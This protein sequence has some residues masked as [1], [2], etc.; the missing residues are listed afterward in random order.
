MLWLGYRKRYA[1]LTPLEKLLAVVLIIGSIFGIIATIPTIISL[2]KDPAVW[3]TGVLQATVLFGVLI[4]LLILNIAL[5]AVIAKLILVL[6]IRLKHTSFH[7]SPLKDSK[8]YLGGVLLF[9]TKFT[10]VLQN[11]FFNII[12]R[13][14][15]WEEEITQVL[16]D[17]T[18][19]LGK[20]KGSYHNSNIKLKCQIPK[21]FSSGEY[22][23]TVEILD[24]TNWLFSI[25]S[26]NKIH[27]LKFKIMVGDFPE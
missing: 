2:V 10:G 8:Q 18:K 23:I 21:H 19:K 5:G 17:P 24:I 15:Y 25:R 26:T 20:L 7:V 16:Y 12:I 11:G 6:V 3:K 4:G 27:S 14:P 13:S 22:S 1:K 9:D